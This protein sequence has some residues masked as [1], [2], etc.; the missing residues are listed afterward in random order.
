MTIIRS[1][2]NANTTAEEVVTG[3]DLTGKRIVI[4]GGASGI[5]VETARAL[6]KQGAEVTLAVRNLDKGDKTASDIIASTGN[7]NIHVAK[8]DLLDK[9]SIISFVSNWKGSLDVLINNAGVMG[10]PDL[11]RTTDGYEEHFAT[12]YLGHFA[13]AVGLHDAL[14]QAH[15][16]RIVVVSSAGT[17]GQLDFPFSVDDLHF[18]NRPYNPLIAYGQ[19]K[20]ATVLFAIGATKHWAKDGITANALMPGA[21]A[22]NLQRYIDTDTLRSWGAVDNSG[23]RLSQPEGWKTPQ[24]GAATSVLLA[25]SPLLEAIGGRFFVDCNESDTAKNDALD[26]KN[27]DFLWDTYFPLINKLF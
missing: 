27:V 16:S 2:F 23:N 11:R 18:N 7:M 10:I 3:I 1:P 4:T 8:L 21:I 6:A 14:A 26:S 24:Q 22:T 5:G 13:L 9:Q 20:V 17:S 12:N 15:S 19:S 25:S